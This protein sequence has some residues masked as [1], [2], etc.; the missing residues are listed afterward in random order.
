MASQSSNLN[1]HHTSPDSTSQIILLTMKKCIDVV[2]G[3]KQ[4]VVQMIKIMDNEEV[5][6]PRQ[7]HPAIYAIQALF[8]PMWEL[9]TLLGNITSSAQFLPT[10]RL[11]LV[12]ALHAL[13]K[14]AEEVQQG[15][16]EF[17][18]QLSLTPPDE[19]HRLRQPLLQRLTDFQKQLHEIQHTL[20]VSSGNFTSHTVKSKQESEK[21]EREEIQTSTSFMHNKPSLKD[22]LQQRNVIPVGG[23]D[24]LTGPLFAHGYALVIGVG[25]DLLITV[26]D[27]QAVSNLLLD[28]QR[29]AYPLQ[30][31]HLLTEQQA[32]RAKILDELDWLSQKAQENPEAT[33]IFYFSGHGG[34][35]PHY[36]LVPRDYDHNNI[37]STAIS[38]RL[39]TE[40]LQAICSQKL[41]VVL[42]C[43][44]AGGMALAKAGFHTSPMPSEL[45]TM[46]SQ[47][48]GKVVIASS[49]KDEIS[50][51]STPYSVFT[52]AFLEALAGYGA[53]EQDG[54]AYIADISLYVGRMVANRTKDKQ[55]PL[56]NMHGADNFKVAF[57]A[58]GK[59]VPYSL[60]GHPIPLSHFSLDKM[61]SDEIQRYRSV[62]KQYRGNLL[63]VEEKMAEF[64]DQASIPPDL[65]RSKAAIIAK[66]AE[67]EDKIAKQI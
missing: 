1:D 26:E 57:Y 49:R 62:H 11:S 22:G 36:H 41:L 48:R 23:N 32:S 39:L 55:H 7:C 44:H 61:D 31:V 46:L 45:H 30:Q 18:T 60:G 25:G 5:V 38:G 21:A 17:R 42:D 58:G 56:L 8:E 50:L 16:I 52:Q 27:A 53:A 35:F 9:H 2:K 37:S 67:I 6:S 43:C 66:L 29:C 33:V 12:I 54:Y 14:Q 63:T 51:T 28:P 64:I 4:S 24:V 59:K 3:T 65:L 20:K 19:Q 15:L 47:G 40:K 13:L 10:S 34:D